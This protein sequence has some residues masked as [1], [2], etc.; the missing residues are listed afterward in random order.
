MRVSGDAHRRAAGHLNRHLMIEVE[1]HV[2]DDLVARLRDGEHGVHERH[3]GAG[4]HHDAAAAPDVDAVF[5]A[6]LDRQPFDE[7]WLPASVLVLVRGRI[8][9]RGAHGVER[10]GRR[11]IMDDA[12]AERDGAGHLPNEIADDRHDRRL[13]GVHAGLNF[14]HLGHIDTPLFTKSRRTRRSRSHAAHEYLRDLRDLRAFV[15]NSSMYLPCG[16]EIGL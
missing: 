11:P 16:R 12:L 6:Q 15:M 10:R 7:G 13:H 8:G 1:R 3:V 9:E 14:Q 5:L 4:G 2:Q